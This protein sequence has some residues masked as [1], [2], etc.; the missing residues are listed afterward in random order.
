MYRE[1]D[2]QVIMI[3]KVRSKKLNERIKL[4]YV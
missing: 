1:C 3:K 4:K 2:K